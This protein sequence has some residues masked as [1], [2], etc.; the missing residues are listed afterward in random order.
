MRIKRATGKAANPSA[1]YGDPFTLRARVPS[2]PVRIVANIRPVKPIITPP[3][4]RGQC[5]RRLTMNLP[6]SSRISPAWRDISVLMAAVSS[7]RD[8][9]F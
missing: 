4:F 1:G 8:E 7:T 9:L 2:G 5:P 3:R 6:V